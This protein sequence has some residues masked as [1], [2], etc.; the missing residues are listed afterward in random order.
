MVLGPNSHK[1]FDI[2]QNHKPYNTIGVSNVEGTATAVAKAVVTQDVVQLIIIV[3]YI[4]IR[5]FLI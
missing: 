1:V 2:P 4:F 3:V 5:F